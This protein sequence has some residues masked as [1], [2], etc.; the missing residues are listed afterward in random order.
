MRG[1]GRFDLRAEQGQTLPSF[2]RREQLS[3]HLQPEDIGR[4]VQPEVRDEQV[5][6]EPDE[7]LRQMQNPFEPHRR[8]NHESHNQRA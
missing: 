3:A 6:L 8:I 7:R 1:W 5:G 2:V 4:F